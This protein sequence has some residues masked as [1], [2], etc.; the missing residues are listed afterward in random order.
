MHTSKNAVHRNV[1]RERLVCPSHAAWGWIF[2]GAVQRLV[3]QAKS[4]S[5]SSI[6][7]CPRLFLL[8][9]FKCVF[10]FLFS[11]GPYPSRFFAFFLFSWSVLRLFDT[12]QLLFAKRLCLPAALK[13]EDNKEK[14][15][16]T[17]F[18]FFF[19]PLE[20]INTRGQPGTQIAFEKKKSFSVLFL[21]FS[22][23]LDSM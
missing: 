11:L 10:R 8:A 18:F 1:K 9:L 7:L 21:Y 23:L 2:Y 17:F 6:R 22:N 4:N 20:K 5:S 19:D 15:A 12:S 3:T 13:E 14:L 16:V